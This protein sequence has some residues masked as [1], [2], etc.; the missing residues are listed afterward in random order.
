MPADVFC[1]SHS[2][3][4][5]RHNT[6]MLTVLFDLRIGRSSS[7]LLAMMSHEEQCPSQIEIPRT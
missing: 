7:L 2:R 5:A 6:D 3:P 4:D 1:V